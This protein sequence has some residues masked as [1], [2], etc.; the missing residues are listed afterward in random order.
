[1]ILGVEA[2]GER[3]A[4][5]ANGD[6][7]VLGFAH[8]CGRPAQ[9][10][11]RDGVLEDVHIPLVVH[12]KLAADSAGGLQGEELAEVVVGAQWSMRVMGDR[13]R[14]GEAAVVIGY[15]HRQE[16]RGRR[17]IVE[18]PQPQLFDETILQRAVGALHATLGFGAAGTE[19]VD[20]ERAQGAAELREARSGL[21]PL[22][23]LDMKDAQP[24]AVEGHRLAMSLEIAT[25]GAEVVEGRLD[26]GKAEL[27]EAARGVVDV[28]E[29]GAHRPA[30]FEPGVLGAVELDELAE[31]QARR[32]RGG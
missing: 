20:V 4:V 1:V 32:G 3:P 30:V 16:R 26:G 11:G 31:R 23:G 19:Q 18:S 8:H 14:F 24:I 22:A 29:Q 15:E 27:H 7:A 21:G 13:R 25:R 10:A 2:G 5:D 6:G 28:D 17:G 12:R 9:R